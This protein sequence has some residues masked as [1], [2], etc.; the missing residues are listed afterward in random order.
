MG[1]GSSSAAKAATF[2]AVFTARLNMLLKNS[3]G[4]RFWEGADLR[5]GLS[6]LS[7]KPGEPRQAEIAKS[8]GIGQAG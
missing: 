6:R 5:S 7:M 8:P 4:N 2:L 1:C 3:P